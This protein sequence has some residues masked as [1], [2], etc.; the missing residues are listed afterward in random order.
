MHPSK[1]GEEVFK[2]HSRPMS[3]RSKPWANLPWFIDY[4]ITRCQTQWSTVCSYSLSI[5]VSALDNNIIIVTIH[6]IWLILATISCIDWVDE[7]TWHCIYSYCM[8]HFYIKFYILL[9]C[10]VLIHYFV[11][12]TP[13]NLNLVFWL[14]FW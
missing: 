9:L 12:G 4:M 6:Y 10:D 5:K 1:G 7:V 3:T 13:Q 2:D 11:L 8:D 14:K